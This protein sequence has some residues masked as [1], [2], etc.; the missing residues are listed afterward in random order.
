[1]RDRTAAALKKKDQLGMDPGTASNQLVKDLLWSF[2]NTNHPFCHRCQKPLTRET[3]SIDHIIPW[4]DAQDPVN[5]FFSL[6]N[7]AYSHLFCNTADARRPKR[8]NEEAFHKLTRSEQLRL[9]SNRR[10]DAKRRGQ[11]HRAAA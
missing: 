10:Q 8:I 7:I 3:F 2:V 4:L 9:L 5:M 11:P 6:D 1:M